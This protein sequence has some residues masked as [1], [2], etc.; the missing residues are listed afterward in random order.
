MPLDSYPF[1]PNPHETSRYEGSNQE[2]YEID[3]FITKKIEKQKLEEIQY[4]SD[5]LR[6][7]LNSNY[8]RCHICTLEPPCNHISEKDVIEQGQKLEKASARKSQIQP[9]RYQ[10]PGDDEV[11]FVPEDVTLAN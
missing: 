5:A 7:F 9:S 1:D 4:K 6:Q 10:A 2:E 8:G 3:E 11:N